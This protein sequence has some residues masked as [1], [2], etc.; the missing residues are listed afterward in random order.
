PRGCRRLGLRG[1]SNLNRQVQQTGTAE[2]AR[3]IVKALFTYPIKSC[4]GVELPASEVESS[5][6]RYDRLFCFAQQ[7]PRSEKDKAAGEDRWRFITQR[8]FPKL[9]LL[10]TELW[11]PEP[12]RQPPTAKGFDWAAQGGCVVISFPHEP[13]LNAL[14]LRTQRVNIVIPLT[15]TSQRAEAKGYSYEQLSIWEDAARALNMT[16][17][18]DKSDLQKLAQF[19]GVRNPLAL[20]RVDDSNKRP[21]TRCLPKDAS[22]ND[23]RVGFG[24]AF[25]VNLM[26]LASVKAIDDSL[27]SDT[28]AKGQLDPT[29]F[30]A[31]FY[32]TGTAPFTEDTWK[33]IT[34]GRRIGRNDK[35]LFEC[36]AEYHVACRTARCKLPNVDQDTGVKDR[37][38]PYTTLSKT[39]KVD[40]GAYP[41][42]CLGMQTIPMFERGIIRVGDEV[43]ILETGE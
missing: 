29:R 7:L 36:D 43:Q 26:G 38:E 6:L 22:G 16:K 14:G 32:I 37:N 28:S 17:E 8:E 2:D 25:P 10:Q 11:I 9:A 39:R 18:I 21:V 5:G 13:S 35:G 23:F 1:K 3:P 41:H 31:N 33:K 24:D 4:R 15:P 40:T 42:P 34:V 30:R 27:P 12:K 20:F 19:I